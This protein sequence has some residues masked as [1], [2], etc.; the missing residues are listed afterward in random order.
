VKLQVKSE[1][2]SG[3]FYRKREDMF[4]DL[5][6][7][8]ALICPHIHHGSLMEVSSS[9]SSWPQRTL[10]TDPEKYPFTTTIVLVL[11]SHNLNPFHKT[12]QL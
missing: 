2:T 6:R 10:E 7:K 3:K 9:P 12:V 4:I 8:P 1:G 11:G 5:L